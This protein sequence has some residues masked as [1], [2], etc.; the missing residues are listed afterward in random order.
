MARD[1]FS[2]SKPKTKKS[3]KSE[4]YKKKLVLF[5]DIVMI[6]MHRFRERDSGILYGFSLSSQK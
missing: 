5:V 6:H 1:G 3:N 4:F 2:D